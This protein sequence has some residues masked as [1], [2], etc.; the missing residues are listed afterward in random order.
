[1]SEQ[2]TLAQVA[3]AAGVSPATASRVLTGSV[4]V[5]TSTRLQVYDAMS[6]LGYV[7]QRGMR[8]TSARRPV[9]GVTVF[10]CDHLPRLFTEPYYAR[11][12]SAAHTALAEHGAQLMVTTVAPSA[13][14]L[15]VLTSG[16]EGVLLIGA[17][18]RHPLAIK[19]STSGM[20]MCNIGRPPHDLKVPYIDADNADG[21]RQAAEHLL[22]LGRRSFAVIGGPPSLP[23][24]QDRLNGFVQTL[25]AA[26]VT[27]VPVAYGDYSLASGAHATQWLLRHVPG[28][29]AL[30]VAS[31]LMAAGAIQALTRAG[32]RVPTNVAVVGFDDAPV[33]RRTVP[34]LT[35][36][37]Q[38][39]EEIAVIAVRTLLSGAPPGGQILPVELILRDSA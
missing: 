3:A 9:G 1:M 19:L 39:V 20:P 29:D 14:A 27:D 6:K 11:F 31:D 5:T 32:R 25:R 16:V 34:L 18:E 8:G 13:T 23:S 28:F 2:P 37:R 15:P 38:P 17:R 24:A 22:L 12:L 30:F 4:R 33:A 7:R 26:G 35:T 10:V 36:V 21:G